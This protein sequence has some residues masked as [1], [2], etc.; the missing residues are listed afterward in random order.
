[1][2]FEFLEF[3][4]HKKKWY[5]FFIELEF[6]KLKFHG[7]LEFK[8]CDRFSI[9]SQIVVDPYIFCQTMVL[10][11]F[12]HQMGPK[13]QFG[14]K[15]PPILLQLLYVGQNLVTKLVVTLRLQPYSTS[16]YW[17]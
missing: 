10:G 4:F 6:V 12:D 11:H 17:R 5:L 14:Q 9:I 1:M 16:F 8:K 2:E 3:K 13:L 7:K 15:F